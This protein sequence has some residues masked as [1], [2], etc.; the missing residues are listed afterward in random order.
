MS[1]VQGCSCGSTRS[2]GGAKYVS[3]ALFMPLYANACARTSRVQPCLFLNPRLA[4]N[5]QLVKM[6]NSVITSYSTLTHTPFPKCVLFSFKHLQ[7]W[8]NTH[9]NQ[10]MCDHTKRARYL[11]PWF[12]PRAQM[13][14]PCVL[15]SFQTCVYGIPFSQQKKMLHRHFLCSEGMS[16]FVFYAFWDSIGD[17]SQY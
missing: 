15:P 16:I 13:H 10:G 9:F 4:L 14:R 3:F 6:P 1:S 12:E 17:L 11:L 2:F 7:I 5:K 8:N